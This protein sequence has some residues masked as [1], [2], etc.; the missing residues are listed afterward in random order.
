MGWW[1]AGGTGGLIGG[2]CAVYDL[3]GYHF[4]STAVWLSAHQ[5]AGTVPGF[6]AYFFSI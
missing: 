2:V 3:Q 6:W 4:C 5:V 1:W